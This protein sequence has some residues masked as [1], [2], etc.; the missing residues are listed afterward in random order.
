MNA[1][2]KFKKKLL[3]SLITASVMT[4]ATAPSASW[5]QSAY[6]TLRGKAPPNTQVTAFNPLTGSTRHAQSAADGSYTMTG[7]Q[8]GTY[9]VDAGSGTQ[10][11]VTLTV[12]ST[13]SLNLQAAAAPAAPA[14]AAN[15]TNLNAV[16]VSASTLQ[17]VKTPEVGGTISLHQINTI[18]QVSRNFLE[19]ADTVPGMVFTRDANG[20][21]SLRGGGQNASSSNVYIDGVGQKSYVKAGG[22]SGQIGSQG[23]PFPQLAIGEYKVITSNYK[24]EYDQISSAA[25][26]AQT[27]SGTNE[28]HG[29]AFGRYTNDAFRERTPAE[30]FAGKKTQS[31][32]KEYGFAIGGPIIQDKMHFFATY[33]A[34]RFNTP[35]TVSADSNATPGI[36]LLPADAAAQL[37]PSN[38]PFEEN[39]YFGKIDWEPTDRDRFELSAQIRKETQTGGVGSGSVAASAAYQTKNDDKRYTVRWQHSGDAYFNELLVSHEDSFNAPV[40]NN[41]GNGY[42]YT[43]PL[44]NADPTIISI[45]AAS[46]LATQNKGQ[47]GPS[48]QDDFT[49]NDL[50][51][52][53]D[54]V[55]KMGAKY[56]DITLDAADALNINP[57]FYYD[58]T[59]GSN[60]I[61]Y[62]AFF[63]KPVEGLGL[64]PT[65]ETKAKQWGLYIQDDWAVTDKL[66]LNL[67]VRWD[68]E[69]N[70]SYTDFVTP[71]N[72]VDAIYSQDPNAPAGQTYAQS[73][74]NGGVNVNDY[75]STGHNRKNFRG[76]WQPRVGFSYD[77]NNDEQHVIHG[78]YGRA[79]DRNLFDYLQ[80]ETTKAALPEYT[81]Y[82]RDPA[83][84]NC[85]RGTNG[86]DCYNFDPSYLN[87]LT[88]LQG[89]LQSSNAGTEVDVLNNKLKAPYSD[90]FS[91]GMSNQLGDWHTDATVS[92]VLSRDGFAFTLGNRY[93]NGD[94]FQGASQP[95]GNG[96]PGFGALIVGNNGIQTKTTQVLLSASKPYDKES[97]WGTTF[98]YTYSQAKQN[99]DINEH[100]SFDYAT[101]GQY[102]FVNSNAVSKHRFV[103][104]GVMDGPWGITLSAKLTLATPIPGNNNQCYSPYVFPSG[105]NCTTLASTPAGN[106][107][108]LVGGKAFGYRDV[109]FQA[110]KN[111][112]LGHGLTL[113]GRFDVLNAFNFRNYTGLIF[114]NG[115]NPGQVSSAYDPRGD[116]TFVPRTFKFEIGMRF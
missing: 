109:D 40:A 67:G 94:F 27:K 49:L 24:A 39:L 33:E 10:Q 4:L 100:Y 87:G 47:K 44:P 52:Y 77:I 55:I 108:F 74:A 102:P 30:E 110:T 105:S 79:Y 114:T 111:F 11:T 89:L 82:F 37:G 29:E 113:Y 53:G 1:T 5:A 23:N 2:T 48:I 59:Q 66:T 70:P 99:R 76:E 3:A 107:R 93:P 78:G 73:L 6:A 58:V 16:S 85:H 31:E 63:T 45:G 80:L 54:H 32:E 112:D 41:L 101:I 56:K 104:T 21:T 62:K 65:V 50:E 26:T 72:V 106:G 83:T 13:A 116:I 81:V 115:A 15:A 25:V 36:P 22:V 7:L 64:S 71:S 28:F 75:I 34:K 96:V 51:W 18:P 95:W 35:V 43:Y 92:R 98:A 103:A 61:P 9:Q 12:A 91:L 57:Q 42:V 97:G 46:P 14:S 60:A 17:E 38:L 69:K 84:G 86:N 19:F 68:Y 88:N 90:Q 8:P 20:N